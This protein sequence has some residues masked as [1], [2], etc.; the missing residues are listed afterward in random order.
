MGCVYATTQ[1]KGRGNKG[2]IWF[3]EIGNFFGSIFFPLK[4][5]YPPFNEFSII[6]PVLVSQM[7]EKFCKKEL[8]TFKWPNDIFVN[9]KKICGILQE[10]ITFNSNNF[11]VIG[12]G[13]NLISNPNIKAL[14]KTTNIFLESNQK[15]TA[16]ELIV[17]LIK[18][19]DNFFKELESYNFLNF[20][21][22]VGL[23]SKKQINI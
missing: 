20:K 9:G 18:S 7:I 11:L 19:Y 10:V 14:Y 8:I 21:S 16:N 4:K 12:V 6:N 5:N 13:I 1:T 23:L 2:K 17:L 3:S 22:K 15:P